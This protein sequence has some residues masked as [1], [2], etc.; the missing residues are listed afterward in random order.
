MYPI[1]QKSSFRIIREIGVR[2]NLSKKTMTSRRNRRE[3][4]SFKTMSKLGP[5]LR[6]SHE[7]HHFM[8]RSIFSTAI[9]IF[10]IAMALWSE[11]SSGTFHLQ[12]QPS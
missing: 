7:M 10:S 3:V 9:S 2:R 4:T 5:R 6:S 1:Q 11:S 8:T 12:G